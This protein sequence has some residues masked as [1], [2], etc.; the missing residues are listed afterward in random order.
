[1]P[2][3]RWHVEKH[4]KSGGGRL[5]AYARLPQYVVTRYHVYHALTTECTCQRQVGCTIP[6]WY[7]LFRFQDLEFRFSTLQGTVQA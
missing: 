3:V 2:K 1:M 7:G 4:L 5:I 6:P